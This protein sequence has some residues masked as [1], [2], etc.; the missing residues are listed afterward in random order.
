MDNLKI[1]KF[2]EDG[3][4]D[5]F[6]LVSNEQVMARI[7]GRAIPFDEAQENYRKLIKRNEKDRLFG[8]YKVY[9]GKTHAFIGLFHMTLNEKKPE[10]AEIGY[11]ILPEYWGRGYGSAIAKQLI[12]MTKRTKL[13]ILKAVI[14]PENTASRKILIK[15]GFTS[16]KI[17]EIDGLPGEILSKSLIRKSGG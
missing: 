3:F 13:S 10:E 7:T 8:S 12:E 15:L 5:Y 2:K 9:D 17:G 6:Q 4:N 14:D 11:M 1:E 16:E